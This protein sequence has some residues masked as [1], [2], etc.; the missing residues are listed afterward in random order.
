MIN[1]IFQ[2]KYKSLELWRKRSLSDLERFL[3]CFYKR[4]IQVYPHQIDAK[5]VTADIDKNNKA[6]EGVLLSCGFKI[7]DEESSRYVLLKKS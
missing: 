7:C 1:N 2:A 4:G 5:R 3:P 6:S